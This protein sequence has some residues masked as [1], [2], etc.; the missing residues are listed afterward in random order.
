M[1]SFFFLITNEVCRSAEVFCLDLLHHADM[2]RGFRIPMVL[3]LKIPLSLRRRICGWVPALLFGSLLISSAQENPGELP[4]EPP[5]WFVDEMSDESS[6]IWEN[7]RHNEKITVAKILEATYQSQ[8]RGHSDVE[9]V[10]ACLL[11]WLKE[12]PIPVLREMMGHQNYQRRVFA[13]AIAGDLGDVRLKVD[14]SRLMVDDTM[15][16]ERLN[17]R[18]GADTVGEVAAFAMELIQRRGLFGRGLDP[19][20]SRQPWLT[21]RP[22]ESREMSEG[23]EKVRRRYS[24]AQEEVAAAYRKNL[25]EVISSAVEVEIF[26]LDFESEKVDSGHYFWDSRL[27]KD[28]FP[29]VPYGSATKILQRKKLSADEIKSLMPSLKATV[30][31]E[32]NSYG[33]MCH[34]PIHGLR[35]SNGE[36]VIFQTSICYECMNFYTE[37]GSGGQNASWTGLSSKEFQEVM[38]HLMPIPASEIERFE[39]KKRSMRESGGK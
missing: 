7:I 34:F 21:L 33:A 12:D 38:E 14:L 27:P 35:I 9:L 36:E 28:Q 22:A 2:I 31:V 13:A 15:L 17:N 25:A 16:N 29:I 5:D 23:I 11:S 26:L 20:P 32:K 24:E 1:T 19:H 4:L 10:A 3:P 39:K 30:G 8:A 37:Y 6:K 18:H